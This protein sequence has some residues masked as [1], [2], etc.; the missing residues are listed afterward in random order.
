MPMA[1][2]YLADL[3]PPEMRGRYMGISGL[4][5]ATALIVGPSLGMKLYTSLPAVYWVAC[6]TLGIFAAAVI[7]RVAGASRQ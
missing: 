3:A 2:A 1:A 4:T 5:W 7:W 6:A